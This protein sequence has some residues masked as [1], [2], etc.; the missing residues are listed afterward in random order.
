MRAA[1]EDVQHRSGK[2]AGV[3][4]AEIAIEG[5]LKRLRNGARGGHGDGEDGIR[6]Q[7]AF[8]GRAVERDHGLVDEALVG[9][10]HAFEFGGD[11]GLNVR[12]CLQNAFAQV[13]ALVA[14]AQFHGLVFAGGSAR[15]HNGA[16]QG[17]AFKN[18]IRFH[19]RIAARVKNFA[20]ANGNNLSH[21]TPRNAVLQ[22]VIQ[23]GT[24]IHGKSFS[25]GALNRIQKLLHVAN[26]FLR[27]ALKNRCSS[28]RILANEAVQDGVAAVTGAKRAAMQRDGCRVLTELIRSAEGTLRDGHLV[29]GATKQIDAG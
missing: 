15:R 12:D 17:A 27:P 18:Y 29:D 26:S 6:A 9:C 4:A 7:L 8:V 19:G 11:D 16:A 25:G 24:A 5:N 2:N 23:F 28:T 22:P 20:R 14:V 1:I 21:I 13:V 10:V 3:D